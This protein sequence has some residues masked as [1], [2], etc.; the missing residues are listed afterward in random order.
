MF[1]IQSTSLV[2]LS[3]APLL[4]HV[5]IV[6]EYG[7]KGWQVIAV[8]RRSV[9]A[10]RGA[11]RDSSS[12]TAAGRSSWNSTVSYSRN[13]SHSRIQPLRLHKRGGGMSCGSPFDGRPQRSFGH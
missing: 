7:R 6:G 8:A 1:A 4:T 2:A 13:M 3:P 12:S 5:W 11:L 9:R 10:A